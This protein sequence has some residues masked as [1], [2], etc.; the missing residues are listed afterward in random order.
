M[1]AVLSNVNCDSIVKK[2]KKVIP[3]VET[4]GFGNVIGELLNPHSA[5]NN[6]DVE[7]VAVI[8]DIQDYL[9]D[10]DDYV[11]VI[12]D[13]FQMLNQGIRFGK[14]YFISD[15]EYYSPFEGD[16][17]GTSSASIITQHWNVRLM[18]LCEKKKECYVFPYAAMIRK[19]GAVNFYS[20]KAW[21]LGSVRYSL[22]GVKEI[23][24]ELEKIAISARGDIKKVLVLDLDN[25]LWGGVAGEDGLE[26]I[27]LADNG[28]GSA[29]K[30]FQRVL[31]QIKKTG[32]LL[33]L[34]SKNN[35]P[36]AWEIIGNHPHMILKKNDFAAYRINWSNKSKNLQEIAQEL[37][38]GLDSL[39]FVDDNPTE[40][41]EIKMAL[42]E[43]SIPEFPTSPED[44]L[45]FA[46]DLSFQYFK[47]I[48]ITQ[49]DR[50][51]TEQYAA[52]KRVESFKNETSDYEGFLKGLDICL[53]RVDAHSNQERLIQLLQKT[54]QFNTTLKRY[55]ANEISSMLN[56]DKWQFYFYEVSDK[57]ANHGLSALAIVNLENGEA[58][59][60][61]F[62]M[63]CRVMGRNIELGI[64]QDVENTIAELGYENLKAL[65]M[66]G[67]KNMPVAQLYDNAGYDL[68][69]SKE[70][71]TLYSKKLTQ[72]RDLPFFGRVYGLC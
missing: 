53:Q 49:E 38:V 39:V 1:L 72:Q 47:K 2:M 19:Y 11:R 60:D 7:I 46:Q 40:R 28:V 45:Q 5:V 54:N 9:K 62:V 31:L 18:E 36:D 13:F 61:N 17:K 24:R 50:Q 3:V 42:P 57:F 25:T 14:K 67:P 21:Y 29:F 16:Y 10:S 35:E 8:V 64:L 26:G 30:D 37:N 27:K 4:N 12:D 32:A 70:E 71:C 68:T 66:Q 58:V 20:P 55:S 51:K 41:E 22:M 65:Y 15:G 43:V 59:I 6:G 23:C 63:S 48:M 44:M 56:N 33:A 34:C 69:E 52:K